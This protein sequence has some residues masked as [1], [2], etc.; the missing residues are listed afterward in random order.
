MYAEKNNRSVLIT[1]KFIIVS[2]LTLTALP[3]VFLGLILQCQASQDV[4]SVQSSL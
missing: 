4:T 1:G 2:E 3:F